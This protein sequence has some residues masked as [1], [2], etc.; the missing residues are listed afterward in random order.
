MNWGKCKF[1]GL[2]EFQKKIDMLNRSGI[3]D[4]C[5]EASKALAARLLAL[6]IPRTPVG[7]YPAGSGK[8]GGTLRRGWGGRAQNFDVRKEGHNYVVE[9]INPTEYAS[10]VEFGHRTRNGGWV[11]GQYFLTI[12]EERLRNIAPGVLEKLIAQKLKEYLNG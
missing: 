5:V 4:I 2:E 1:D 10:Y 6:V 9:I 8:Q 3:D 12:S 7:V 11:P